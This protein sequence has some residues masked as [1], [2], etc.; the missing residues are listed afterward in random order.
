MSTTGSF[1]DETAASATFNPTD[2]VSEVVVDGEF[3]GN[4]KLQVSRP[5]ANS[6][7][8][9]LM[10]VTQNDSFK[11]SYTL[12]TPDAALDY[13]FYGIGIA[14]TANYYFGP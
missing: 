3:S 12:H 2:T 5:D 7:V 10:I 8:D 14:G 11:Q 1:T 4:L 9:V 13:R 6:W